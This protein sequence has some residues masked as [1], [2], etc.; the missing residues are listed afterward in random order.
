MRVL[1]TDGDSRAALAVTRALGRRGH[2]VIVGEKRSPALAQV[3]RYCAASFVY[4]DPAKDDAGFLA[5]LLACVRERR[6]DV[7][8]PIADVAALV[9]AGRRA[10]FEPLCRLPLPDLTTLEAAADKAGLVDRARRLDVPVP[11]SARI[12]AADAPV[13]SDLTYPAVL[14]PHRSRVRTPD[15]WRSCGVSY[16]ETPESLRAQLHARHPA[17]FP[18]LLQE[19]LVGPG[20]GVFVCCDRSHRPVAVFSHR[21]IREKPPWGGVSVLC[22]SA[23]V[24]PEARAY[25]EALLADLGWFG[26]AMV[27]FKRDSRDGRPKLMEING[28]FWGSLQLAVDAGVDF[29]SILLDVLD[30]RAGAPPAYR[31]GVKSRWFWGDLD[32]LV[33]RLRDGSRGR[34]GAGPGPARAVF[35]FCKL[36]EPGLRYENPRLDDPRPWLHETAR[37][38]KA[39]M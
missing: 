35:Q 32:A 20:L 36:W 14:K 24:D 38:L 23:P 6:V 37:W 19:R 28:R 12:E 10:E 25:A 9:A 13:P 26:V 39:L 15:G 8:L 5:A 4:P 16:A 18:I 33:L 22:E 17:E 2:E 31:V 21:R 7:L 1:V 3:S 29:P 11:R 27:E 30:G 34:A